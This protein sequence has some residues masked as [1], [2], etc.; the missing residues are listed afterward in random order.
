M[1]LFTYKFFFFIVILIKCFYL[2]LPKHNNYFF[3]FCHKSHFE[4][5]L[6]LKLISRYLTVSQLKIIN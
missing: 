5:V 3:F 4:K 6:Y 2:N 1:K